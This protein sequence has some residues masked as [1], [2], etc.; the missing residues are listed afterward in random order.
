[1]TLNKNK[2][3]Y[4]KNIVGKGFIATNLGKIKNLIKKN[5]YI[6][7]AAGISNSKIKSKKELEKELNLF[8]VFSK[9]NI[10]KKIIYIS[11]ADVTHNLTNKSK[12]VQNKI[13][14]EKQIKK[15]FK[16]Y[17]IIR[18]PQ[19]IGKSKNKKTLINYF[20]FKIKY[21]EKLSIMKEYKRNIL[22]IDD[23]LKD[24]KIILLNKKIKNKIITLSNKYFIKPI[25]I[26][27]TFEKKLS[28]KA[29]YSF[30]NSPKQNWNL[31]YKTNSIYFKKANVKFHNNYLAKK[32]NKYY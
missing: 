24:L 10:S 20:Y 8:K 5:K 26:V 28:K 15:K 11:T 29:N 31:N 23:V 18:L 16:H 30:K 32:I 21:N 2:T 13:I 19:I 1:M 4:S 25:D 7:Y 12:Y 3:P 22:D 17:I 27:K 6:I 14:I 9:Q